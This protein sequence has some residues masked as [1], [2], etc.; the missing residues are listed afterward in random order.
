MLC[1]LSILVISLASV[2]NLNVRG[3]PVD[4]TGTGRCRPD[5]FKDDDDSVLLQAVGDRLR[6]A[7]KARAESDRIRSEKE[8]LLH[9]VRTDHEEADDTPARAKMQNSFNDSQ[10][11]MDADISLVQRSLPSQNLS[12]SPGRNKSIQ[13]A[14]V[15][16]EVLKRQD[17]KEPP[18]SIQSR[19]GKAAA[20][21]E[22][23]LLLRARIAKRAGEKYL[24]NARNTGS[25]FPFLAA[26]VLV[27]TCVI[28]CIYTCSTPVFLEPRGHAEIRRSAQDISRATPAL[29][30]RPRL[31]SAA[32]LAP[33][34]PSL[35]NGNRVK[36]PY[37]PHLTSLTLPPKSL[38]GSLMPRADHGPDLLLAAC[39]QSDE[40]AGQG[41]AD[42][43]LSS[44]SIS[45]ELPLP[46]Y[47]ALV[48]PAREA[49]LQISMPSLSS[50]QATG[51]GRFFVLGPLGNKIMYANLCGSALE[52][53]MAPP[54]S[55][56]VASVSR[57]ETCPTDK[58][59]LEICGPDGAAYGSVVE[60]LLSGGSRDAE[61]TSYTVVVRSRSG[62]GAHDLLLVRG[63]PCECR[64][65]ATA[66]ADGQPVASAA[67]EKRRTAGGCHMEIRTQRRADTAL[68]LAT[69]LGIVLLSPRPAA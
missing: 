3:G 13:E 18:Q 48:L 69:F 39:A 68:V 63:S 27:V 52:I 6:Q 66:A 38:R 60:R 36:D 16:S 65:T 2:L 23:S 47:P 41:A 67:P 45:H 33:P 34:G 56:L 15:A 28:A 64:F 9:T 30:S 53:H 58:P 21:L 62:Q 42:G 49:H 25:V 10:N 59:R 7:G 26:A 43:G 20:N 35:G 37:D 24:A 32:C 54:S 19:L 46:L 17:F 5:D 31:S 29:P 50:V 11:R 51:A 8:I 61:Q 1:R 40:A 14:V 22:S 4:Q 44:R 57:V 12:L 55:E